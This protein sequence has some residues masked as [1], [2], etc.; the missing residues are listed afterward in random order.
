MKGTKFLLEKKVSS[1][2]KSKRRDFLIN[3]IDK[4][5]IIKFSKEESLEPEQIP[6]DLSSFCKIC[7]QFEF[8]R[9]KYSE[10]CR[11]CGYERD[12]APTGKVFEKI[13]YIKPGANIVKITKEGK[14]ITVDLN[15]IN[16]WLQDTDP[17]A[18]DTEKILNN[19]EIVFQTRGIELPNTVKNTSI[20]LWYNF[21]SLYKS[22]DIK[23][24]YNKKA[25]LTL[26]TYY[27]AN[28]NQYNISLEQLSLLF[29][30]NISDIRGNNTLFK[31]VF[32]ESDY[33]KYL[34]L[35]ENTN[36]CEV[37]LSPKN[38]IIFS[39]IKYDLIKHYPD[40]SEPLS[41]KQYTGIIYYLTNK[42]NPTLKF[43]LKYLSDKCDG[44]VSTTTIGKF[45]KDIENFYKIKPNLLKELII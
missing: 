41:S 20:A 29:N 23:K 36:T 2:K 43:T 19:L 35:F 9:D 17:L 27:G 32:E 31:Q 24:S 11:N 3:C 45:A 14:N 30:I 38:K 28:I 16:L 18:N 22:K 6:I 44:V 8:I 33:Y 7:N 13:E 4:N 1:L 12:I 5:N 15:K 40:I 25:I 34:N 37:T 39:K 21:N 42:I 26:C 10:T